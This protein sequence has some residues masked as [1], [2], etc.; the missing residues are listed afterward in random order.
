M[1]AQQIPRTLGMTTLLNSKSNIINKASVG[2]GSG[3]TDPR[4][5]EYINPGGHCVRPRAYM[6]AGI[7]TSVSCFVSLLNQGW[8]FILSNLVSILLLNPPC[9]MNSNTTLPA[10]PHVRQPDSFEKGRLFEDCIIKLFNEK[11]FKLIKWRKAEKVTDNS[12]LFDRSNPDL[13]L[14]FVGAK[15]HRFAVECKW[16]KE[17][18]AGKIDWANSYQICVYEDFQQQ[19]RIPVFIAIGVGGEPSNPEKLFVTPL[20]QISMFTEVYESELIPYKRKP[21]HRFF[22]NTVQLKLF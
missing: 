21:T 12:Y 7:L 11:H 5:L 10:T 17:F 15:R 18:I 1:A 22:Y 14:V 19:N 20:D 4:E 3:A 16:R 13:E 6:K 2:P 8:H 9:L